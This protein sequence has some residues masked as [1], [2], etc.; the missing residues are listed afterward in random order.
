[1]IIFIFILFLFFLVLV[2]F[3]LDL[4]HLQIQVSL[5]QA[6]EKVLESSNNTTT[7]GFSLSVNTLSFIFFL[8]PVC[9]GKS[10]ISLYLYLII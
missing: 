6:E 10:S 4:C 1:M 2:S 8:L 7:Q 5:I 3:D 9:W